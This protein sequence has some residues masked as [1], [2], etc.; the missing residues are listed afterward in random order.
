MKRD[1]AAQLEGYQ[2]VLQLVQA[3]ETLGEDFSSERGAVSAYLNRLHP[4]RLSLRVSHIRMETPS[5]KTFRM[6]PVDGV[7]PP[8]RPGSMWPCRWR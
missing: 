4:A 2:D 8:F 1:I 3:A 6:V 5:T 7:L